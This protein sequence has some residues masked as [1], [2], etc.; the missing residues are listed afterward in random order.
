M[1]AVFAA[2]LAMTG[3]TVAVAYQDLGRLSAVVALAIASV[4]AGLVVLYFMHVRYASKLIRLYAA[5]GFIFVAIMLGI[6]MSEVAGRSP[7]PSAD[8]LRASGAPVR[9][10]LASTAEEV[11]HG[12]HGEGAAGLAERARLEQ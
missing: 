5:A 8:P 11:S 3:L 2:L 9:G 12:D 1:L 10:A 7:Q 4:K 6:T